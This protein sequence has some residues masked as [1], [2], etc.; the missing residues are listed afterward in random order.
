M[1]QTTD[2]EVGLHSMNSNSRRNF[3][4]EKIFL[5]YSKNIVAQIICTLSNLPYYSFHPKIFHKKPVS[6]YS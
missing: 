2:N 6:C 5:K 1:V 4:A 3:N